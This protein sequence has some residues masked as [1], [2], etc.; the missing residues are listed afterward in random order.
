MYKTLVLLLSLV[1]F[2]SPLSAIET[3]TD[4]KIAAIQVLKDGGFYITPSTGSWGASNAAC[5]SAIYVYVVP[6]TSPEW[7]SMLATAMTASAADKDV[8]F[9]GECNASDGNYFDAT[10]IILK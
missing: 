2:S 9:W 10:Q 3:T 1:I 6:S 7:K 5:A 8:Q 4:Q